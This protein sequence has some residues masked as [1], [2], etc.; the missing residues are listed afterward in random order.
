MR[1]DLSNPNAANL[2]LATVTIPHADI[3]T[4]PTTPVELIPAPGVGKR[5]VPIQWDLFGDFSAGAYTNI[6]PA[7]FAYLVSRLGGIDYS[8]YLADDLTVYISEFN[9]FFTTAAKVHASLDVWNLT[10]PS[11]GSLAYGEPAG[12]TLQN[13]A[14][15]LFAANGSAGNLTGGNAANTLTV[16]VLYLVV[17]D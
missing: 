17:E 12:A 10:D 5:I 14:L 7:S 2:S 1:Y 8:S 6:V 11:W 15:D 13:A 16:R 9:D 4:L 3:L